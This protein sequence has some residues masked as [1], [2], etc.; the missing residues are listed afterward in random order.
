VKTFRFALQPLLDA[1]VRAEDEARGVLAVA[2]GAAAAARTRATDARAEFACAGRAFRELAPSLDGAAARE[3]LLRLALLGD[4]AECAAAQ[5]GRCA[6]REAGAR[7]AFA[8]A[9]RERRRIELL[10]A[11]AHARHLRARTDSE[12]LQLDEA[13]EARHN[14]VTLVASSLH[15]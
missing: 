1:R 8:A 6:Q 5:A 14:S 15:N 13:N 7:D 2:A 10:R 12:A 3:L 11:N 4:A 9:R